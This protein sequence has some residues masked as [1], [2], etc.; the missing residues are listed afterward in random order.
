M[1]LSVVLLSMISKNLSLKFLCRL[2]LRQCAALEVVHVNSNAQRV[3][4]QKRC[5]ELLEWIL[6]ENCIKEKDEAFQEGLGLDWIPDDCDGKCKIVQYIFERDVTDKTWRNYVSYKD[7]LS[8][9]MRKWPES[10]KGDLVLMFIY[11]HVIV[12]LMLKKK[13]DALSAKYNKLY[14]DSV[15]HDPSSL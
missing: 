1:I 10:I 4:W 9:C 6:C 3:L 5:D 7:E 2:G 11:E 14:Y 15:E 8:E 13:Q 12:I